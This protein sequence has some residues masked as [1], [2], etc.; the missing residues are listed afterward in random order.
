MQEKLKLL[1]EPMN[2][3]L[4]FFL[5]SLFLLFILFSCGCISNINNAGYTQ[6]SSI[7]NPKLVYLTIDDGPSD[8]LKKKVDYL[9]DR[10]I[11]A[12]FFFIGVHLKEHPEDAIYA[13]KKGFIIG[14]HSYYH[15]KFSNLSLEDCFDEIEKADDLINQIY[16]D[17]NVVRSEKYFRFPYGNKG[18]LDYDSKD[19]KERI[20]I[21]QEFLFNLGYTQISFENINPQY[22]R[23]GFIKNNDWRW[24]CSFGDWEIYDKNEII[25]SK[26]LDIILQ[27]I[28][29]GRTNLCNNLEN[30]N[31]SEIL[32][33][34]DHADNQ[35]AFRAIIDKL[36][37]KGIIFKSFK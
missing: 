20:S 28:N 3:K 37:E 29:K 1:C 23:S 10:N 32:I 2:Y 18:A 12:V 21:I 11:P 6:N 35:I 19:G 9:S 16:D 14:N 33:M 25:D 17:A 13:I 36:L 27:G 4:T 26:D 24:T 31:Y 8:N 7:Y 22:I 30:K 34:H 15:R 5:L